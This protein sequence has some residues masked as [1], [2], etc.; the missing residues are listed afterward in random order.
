MLVTH[1]V[2]AAWAQPRLRNVPMMPRP[3][4]NKCQAPPC[5]SPPAISLARCL[6]VLVVSG[7]GGHCLQ[8]GEAV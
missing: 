4:Q 8:R 1:L 2:P 7:E 6:L 5:S 3:W